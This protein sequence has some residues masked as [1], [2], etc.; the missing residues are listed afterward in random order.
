M[1]FRSGE[2]GFSGKSSLRQEC[3]SKKCSHVKTAANYGGSDK[4]LMK[5]GDL[6]IDSCGCALLPQ[7]KQDLFCTHPQHNTQI[8]GTMWPLKQRY[9]GHTLD[10]ERTSFLEDVM[11]R[12]LMVNYDPPL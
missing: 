6:L 11:K 2:W 4:D 5:G 12:Y 10:R 3:A 8:Q 9:F 7:I 1:G